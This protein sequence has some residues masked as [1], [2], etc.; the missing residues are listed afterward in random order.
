LLGGDSGSNTSVGSD[1]TK[2]HRPGG[3]R[4][5]TKIKIYRFIPTR[6]EPLSASRLALG[7]E[8]YQKQNRNSLGGQVG[9]P[10]GLPLGPRLKMAVGTEIE[11][12]GAVFLHNGCQT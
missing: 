6:V 12:G 8:P 1:T 2:L 11:D 3:G 7:Q 5:T 9:V 10:V 4:P